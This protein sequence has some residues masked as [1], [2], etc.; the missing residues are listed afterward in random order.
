[1]KQT[2]KTKLPVAS[3]EMAR[4][5]TDSVARGTLLFGIPPLAADADAQEI[6]LWTRT[7]K[8][9]MNTM[10]LWEVSY[11][12]QDSRF[13]TTLLNLIDEKLMT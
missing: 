6:P 5:R 10:A 3:V 9:L 11:S 12:I 7:T 13:E 8:K 1:M 2:N 4:E